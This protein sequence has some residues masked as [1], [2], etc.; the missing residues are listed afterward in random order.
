V[1][2]HRRLSGV[3]GFLGVGQEEPIIDLRSS[4]KG[5][6]LFQCL[7]FMLGFIFMAARRSAVFLQT[8]NGYSATTAG[9]VLSRRSG[10]DDLDAGRG[11]TVA[12]VQPR[13]LIG[14]GLLVVGTSLLKWTVSICRSLPDGDARR[15]VQMAGI[16]F[17][18]C[19]STR[20]PYAS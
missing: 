14:F 15:V 3:C 7:M 9:M 4:A 10:H 1:R 12:K 11:A 5:I 6:F 19:R 8:L 20:R 2:D 16:G 13:Y 18:W 17:L